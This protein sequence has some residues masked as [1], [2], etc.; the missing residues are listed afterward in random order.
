[1]NIAKHIADAFAP[2]PDADGVLVPT[3]ILY[4][5]NGHVVVHV[6]GGAHT[7]VVSDRGDAL[8]TARSHSVEIPDVDHWLSITLR[9]SFL[10]HSHGQI[11]SGEMKLDDV[12]AGISLV[13]RAASDAVRYA[14]DHYKP[15]EDTIY[16]R[17]YREM[18]GKFGTPNVSRETNIAGASNRNYRFDFAA[19]IG[20]RLLVLDTVVPNANSV[21]AKAIAH[22]DVGNLK[23]TAPFHAIV[24]DNDADWDASDIN[25]LQSAAQL[26]PIAR[27]SKELGRYEKLN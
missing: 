4:P 23:D 22:I 3:P 14:I 15:L 27:L 13:A 2:I 26:L 20:P 11:T 12:F 19:P 18:K 6:S 9:G 7:C 1:M 8:R 21:N 5:S 25:L 16:E 17:T 24:Y 10:H